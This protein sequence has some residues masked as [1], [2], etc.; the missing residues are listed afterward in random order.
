MSHSV[1]LSKPVDFIITDALTGDIVE[2]DFK[3]GGAILERSVGVKPS[4]KSIFFPGCSL[5]DYG[6]SHT[7]C[8]YNLLTKHNVVDGISVLCCGKIL[9]FEPNGENV[10]AAYEQ[11]FREHVAAAGIER[12]I[13]ACP[14]CVKALRESLSCNENTREIE[15]MPLPQVISDLGY[16]LEEG[17]IAALLGADSIDNTDAQ[18]ALLCP[19]DSCPDRE[20]GAFADGLRAL[21]PDGLW[22]DPKHN[23]SKSVCCGSLPRAAGRIDQADRCADTCGQESKATGARAII[24]VCMSCA[25]QL[26][27]AQKHLPC[28]HFLEFLF[29]RKIDWQ[30]ME[31]YM[32]LRFL[33]NETLGVMEKGSGRDFA[34]LN[35]TK[36]NIAASK[37]VGFNEEESTDLGE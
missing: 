1:D 19:H 21:I 24:T 4:C 12:I 25:F 14:N 37:D 27:M 20:Y 30:S 22:V 17:S 32:K 29:N 23:R 11:D 31:K 34:G 35:A 10:R 7:A 9:S 18:K 13:C 15:L 16:K 6:I 26:N 3:T 33:F 2:F 28:I 36:A 5:I 8:A